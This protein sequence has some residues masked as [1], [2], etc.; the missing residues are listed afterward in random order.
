[1]GDGVLELEDEKVDGEEMDFIPY[2]SVSC[3]FFLVWNRK[4]WP[5]TVAGI[6]AGTR[7]EEKR[8]EADLM[9]GAG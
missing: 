6:I 7:R 5:T 3:C 2:L 1:M 4:A 9:F 8:G